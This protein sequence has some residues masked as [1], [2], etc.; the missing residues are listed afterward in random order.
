MLPRGSDI[1][2]S[3][4]ANTGA[5]NFE[6]QFGGDF[7]EDEDIYCDSGA[8][9]FDVLQLSAVRLWIIH[10]PWESA[11]RRWPII[12]QLQ[13]RATARTWGQPQARQKIAA[14]NLHIPP[15]ITNTRFSPFLATRRL[16]Y[17]LFAVCTVLIHTL[18]DLSGSQLFYL[19]FPCFY[20][21]SFSHR[22]SIITQKHLHT[23]WVVLI[24]FSKC[25]F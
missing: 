17:T 2:S 21:P 1:L 19:L 11:V 25:F 9:S 6:V 24:Q 5:D 16:C 22:L 8:S 23:R 4:F 13:G 12:K 20:S 18:S 15:Q 10:V 14:S 3:R 7:P